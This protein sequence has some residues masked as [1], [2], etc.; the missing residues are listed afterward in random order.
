MKRREFSLL[1]LFI[2]LFFASCQKDTLD[3]TKTSKKYSYEREISMPLVQGN[4]TFNDLLNLDPDTI[5]IINVLDTLGI[6]YN[7]EYN[8]KDTIKLSLRKDNITVDFANLN[9][10]FTNQFPIGLDLKIFLCDSLYTIIDTIL[11]SND[12]SEIFLP[13]APVDTN[14]VVILDQVTEKKG[15]VIISSTTAENLLRNTDQLIMDVHL[16][17]NTFSVVKV[18]ENSYLDFRFAVDVKGKY[19]GYNK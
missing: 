4:I 11:F 3:L 8:F 2:V 13:A 1:L 17:A 15:V 14:G 9:Y 10:W 16:T 19:E 6:Y 12:T 5:Q 7:L 18:L